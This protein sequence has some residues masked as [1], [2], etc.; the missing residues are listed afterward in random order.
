MSSS[1]ILCMYVCIIL[2]IF[3]CWKKSYLL[4]KIT[5]HFTWCRVLAATEIFCVTYIGSRL[6]D[7]TVNDLGWWHNLGKIFIRQ[8][9]KRCWRESLRCSFAATWYPTDLNFVWKFSEN[10]L[11]CT[12]LAIRKILSYIPDQSDLRQQSI[13][14]S[15]IC[16]SP[17]VL[18]WQPLAVLVLAGL[19]F[20]VSTIK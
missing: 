17:V 9:V 5:E 14:I 2:K 7:C 19:E 3:D 13:N 20:D 4:A 1:S 16:S 11:T 12:L 15:N 6:Q 10:L 18:H 8:N